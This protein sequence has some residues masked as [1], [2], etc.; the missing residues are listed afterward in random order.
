M[1]EKPLGEAPDEQIGVAMRVDDLV[2]RRQCHPITKHLDD[3]PQS[4]RDAARRAID[5]LEILVVQLPVGQPTSEVVALQLAVEHRDCDHLQAVAADRALKV[6]DCAVAIA[7]VSGRVKTPGDQPDNTRRAELGRVAQRAERAR[8]DLAGVD[9]D[10]ESAVARRVCETSAELAHEHA[11]GIKCAVDAPLW[12]ARRGTRRRLARSSQSAHRCTTE[13]QAALD[14]LTRPRRADKAPDE[15]RGASERR[16]LVI[17]QL[18]AGL[19]RL[20]VEPVGVANNINDRGQLTAKPRERLLRTPTQPL[21]H[22]PL[23]GVQQRADAWT[24]KRW[25]TIGH[26][27]PLVLEIDQN[28]SRSGAPPG[29]IARAALKLANDTTHQR[30]LAHPTDAVNEHDERTGPGVVLAGVLRRG[31][32]ALPHA[33]LSSA[34][35]K[36][37]DVHPHI[38][39]A[40]AAAG[41][42]AKPH[43]AT[44]TLS[45]PISPA[46]AGSQA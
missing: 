12:H 29:P 2:E 8:S 37:P 40:T 21:A 31:K 36:R 14:H 9:R 39:A 22:G 32:E 15:I 1:H 11:L 19:T 4:E 17:G 38:F 42:P 34:T 13:R 24:L 45:A 7:D 35:E 43:G 23:H 27:P 5:A 30:R 16:A 44:R 25:V 10:H 18:S 33:H 6:P 28:C 41:Q 26:A 46:S 20:A 3:E